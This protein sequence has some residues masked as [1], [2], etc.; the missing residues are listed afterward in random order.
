MFYT[1]LAL[2]L[3]KYKMTEKDL[4]AYNKWLVEV[5]NP[6]QLYIPFIE[7]APNAYLNYIGNK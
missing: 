5:W 3:N 1:L 4:H 7:S 6:N 2:V